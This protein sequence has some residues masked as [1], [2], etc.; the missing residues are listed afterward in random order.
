MMT[1]TFNSPALKNKMNSSFKPAN[2]RQ[3]PNLRA[4]SWGEG[5]RLML[6]V[7]SLSIVSLAGQLAQSRGQELTKEA[8][9]T[10]VASAAQAQIANAKAIQDAR[11]RHK[12]TAFEKFAVSQVRSY[13]ELLDGLTERA[14]MIIATSDVSTSQ[15]ETLK[16]SLRS[17]D[18]NLMTAREALMQLQSKRTPKNAKEL[19][20]VEEDLRASLLAVQSAASDAQGHM[21]GLDLTP[22]DGLTIDEAQSF[23]VSR[24]GQ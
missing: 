17:L 4:F 23:K 21:S 19:A 18:E 16:T 22:H 10:I 13:S 9:A 20:F 14:E 1:A 6:I 8:T 5:L 15:S 12:V 2:F 3:L 24:I 11:P 7:G